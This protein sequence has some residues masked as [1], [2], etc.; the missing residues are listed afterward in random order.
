VLI[1]GSLDGPTALRNR[2]N[3]VNRLHVWI[4]LTVIASRITVSHELAVLRQFPR[5]LGVTPHDSTRQSAR[6]PSQRAYNAGVLQA[7]EVWDNFRA[8]I[9]ALLS[10]GSQNGSELF[11]F[12]NCLEAERVRQKVTSRASSCRQTSAPEAY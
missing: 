12:E 6:T 8:C 9:I 5:F 7:S 4:V 3:V 1:G 10:L 2:S 11:G